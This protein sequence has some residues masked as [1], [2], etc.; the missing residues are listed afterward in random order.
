MPHTH[1]P[2]GAGKTKAPKRKKVV[3]G[4]ATEPSNQ[5]RTQQRARKRKKKLRPR[6]FGS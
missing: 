3:K 6:F 1:K 5:P 4:I 2:P